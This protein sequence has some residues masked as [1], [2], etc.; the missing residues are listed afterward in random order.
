MF[1]LPFS[2]LGGASSGS[3]VLTGRL[4]ARAGRILFS[5]FTMVK[6]SAQRCSRASPSTLVCNLAISSSH[7]PLPN[8]SQPGRPP[9]GIQPAGGRRLACFVGPQNTPSATEYRIGVFVDA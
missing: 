5:P 1:L 8:P 2:A 4:L 9:A 7:E 6:T 3:P